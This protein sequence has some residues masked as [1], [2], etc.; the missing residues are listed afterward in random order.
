MIR[1]IWKKLEPRQRNFA[2]ICAAA[3]AVILILALVVFPLWD[4]RAKMKKSITANTRKLAE[5]EKIDADYAVADA[6]IARIKSAVLSRQ[7]DFTL[8]AYLEKKALAAGVKGSIRQM[9]SMQ[10]VKSPSFEESLID[11]KL[12]KI[13]IRQ[14]AD[15]LYQIE[16]PAELIRIRRITVTK[17]KETPEYVS[18]QML[19]AS[20]TPSSPGPGGP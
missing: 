15:F 17:M 19:I 9:N 5:M 7:A 11:L 18:A 20:C 6:Q 1:E 3:L 14:L 16:S 12:E 4:A 13:T 10:G 2:V 8:F